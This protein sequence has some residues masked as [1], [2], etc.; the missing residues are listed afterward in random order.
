MNQTIH[1]VYGGIGQRLQATCCTEISSAPAQGGGRSLTIQL[2]LPMYIETTLLQ[3]EALHDHIING[4]PCCRAR[5][6]AWDKGM[7]KGGKL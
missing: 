7:K 3:C 1:H 5:D 6:E 2:L 4:S